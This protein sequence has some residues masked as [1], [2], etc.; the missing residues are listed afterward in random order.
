MCPRCG[1]TNIKFP[2]YGEGLNRGEQT[3]DC[4]KGSLLTG[5]D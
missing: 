3:L 1:V 2:P 5:R 4:K